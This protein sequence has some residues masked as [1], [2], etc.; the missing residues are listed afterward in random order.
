MYKYKARKW[1]QIICI[2]LNYHKED[3]KV[4]T[5][6]NVSNKLFANSVIASNQHELKCCMHSVCA[7]KDTWNTYDQHILHNG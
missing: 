1:S 7:V 5:N 4:K 6:Y 3:D 2:Q